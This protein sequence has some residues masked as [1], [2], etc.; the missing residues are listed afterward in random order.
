[1]RRQH[2]RDLFN[3]TSLRS[4]TLAAAMSL[5]GAPMVHAQQ[6]GSTE[7]AKPDRAQAAE[8]DIRLDPV[9][10]EGVGAD[11]Y[12][13]TVFTGAEIE[14]LG[15]DN[16]EQ[17][18]RMTP[19]VNVNSSGGTNLST[20]YIRGVGSMYPMNLSD[21]AVPMIIDGAPVNARHMSLGT[22]DVDR[23]EILK[24]PQGTT[25]GP[26]GIAGAIDITT[27]RPTRTLEGYG[28]VEYG[29]QGQALLE[30]AVGGPLTDALSGRLAVRY[31]R[32]DHWVTNA[33]DGEPLAN[34][35]DLAF[36]GHLLWDAGTGTSALVTV[37]HEAVDQWPNLI[38]LMPYGRNPSVNLTPG[39]YD[40]VGKT[41]DRYALQINHDLDL[42]RI[43]SISS[44][45]R[46]SNTD[47]AAYDR[48]I[49]RAQYGYPSEYW[50]Q[51]QAA[52]GVFTQDL[53]I[54]S[55]AAAAAAWVAGAFF[56]HS[57]ASYDTPLNTY[58][59]ANPK[60]RDFT[61]DT[62]AL[63]AD[64][65]Y[66]LTSALKL[67]LGVRQNW[68]TTSYDA[69]F[70]TGGLASFD[71]RALSEAATTG[72]VMLSYAITPAIELHAKYAR[73]FAP[74]GFNIYSTQV[75]DGEPFKGAVND[76]IE[77]GFSSETEDKRFALT[78]A[79]YVNWVCDNHLLSYDSQTYV[80]SAVN[81]DTRSQGFELNGRWR[82]GNGFELSVGV[83]YVDATITSSVFGVGDGNI[84]AGNAV[85]DVAPWS[86]LAMASYETQLPAFLWLSRPIL[87]GLASYSF[88]G[89]RPAN[90][91]NSLDLAGYHKLDMRLGIAQD[92]TEA[93]VRADNLLDDMYDLY[94][95]Y[96][97]A[98]GIS[99]GG[100]ARGRTFVAGV[101]HR[102]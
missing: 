10:I 81:A 17:V 30:A 87:K 31:S 15:L 101:T 57:D 27:R 9:M 45:V 51:D 72:R 22:L 91:Q 98:F 97:P 18:L 67:T 3:R 77:I 99:Y 61:T 86:L 92:Q 37:E 60:F 70:W 78:G 53:R 71:S 5:V 7:R 2:P 90:P 47:I 34:P 46:A 62:Y 79:A 44:Y 6:S 66:P 56:Q 21:S 8:G 40:D 55:P 25:S 94:G 38:V 43:T 29:Q 95:Y 50:V 102:F 88:V 39:L 1:M 80:V 28:R 13:A 96:A 49:M 35:S 12:T 4:L 23:M 93:Y 100:M 58:G 36:R 73:G 65:T 74:G 48:T 33:A 64:V 14:D 76:M 24:G 69:S 85:P 75:A 26:S 16:I 89:A 84:L 82:P 52:E 59:A 32:S 19:G 42:G 83:S 68:N 20:I 54:S 11:Q 41:F 63:Y